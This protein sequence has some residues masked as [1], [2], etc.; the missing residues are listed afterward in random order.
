MGKSKC[1]NSRPGAQKC[2]RKKI[3]AHDWKS[4]PVLH[5]QAAGIDAGSAEPHVA[6]PAHCDPQ[7]VRRFSSFTADRH[8]MAQ[9]RKTCRIQTVAMPAT[10]TYWI[11]RHPILEEHG[12]GQT[13]TWLFYVRVIF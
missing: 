13:K 11:G 10:G 3:T 2:P 6:G 9:G 1:G 8:R 5:L 4:P 7:P 12:L